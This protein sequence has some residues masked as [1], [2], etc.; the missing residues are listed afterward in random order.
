MGDI[1]E[2]LNAMLDNL[3]ALGIVLT[4]GLKR[5]LKQL[6]LL[7]ADQASK[8]MGESVFELWAWCLLMAGELDSLEEDFLNREP[9]QMAWLVCFD[10][11]ESNE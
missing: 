1:D 7:V 9:N 6:L 10:R 8:H 3:R 4:C 5:V 2:I 11:D